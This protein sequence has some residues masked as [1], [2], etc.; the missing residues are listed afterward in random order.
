MGD[1]SWR[2]RAASYAPVSYVT[3]LAFWAGLLGS[4]LTHDSPSFSM[5]GRYQT[6][7]RVG[8]QRIRYLLL[9][10]LL[11]AFPSLPNKYKRFVLLYVVLVRFGF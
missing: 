11:L 8:T 9:V 4:G 7:I 5:F 6:T 3:Q 10:L 1:R 2:G